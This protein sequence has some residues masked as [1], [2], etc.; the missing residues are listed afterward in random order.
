MAYPPNQVFLGA[1][2]PDDLAGHATPWYIH[3]CRDARPE[4]PFGAIIPQDE[5]Y[6]GHALREMEAG[7]MRS[8]MFVAKASLFLGRMTQMA[9]GMSMVLD[10]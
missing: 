1:L 7:R 9:D 5:L 8:A 10:A 6:C 2:S 3:P 4:A